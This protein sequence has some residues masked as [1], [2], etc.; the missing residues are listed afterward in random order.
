MRKL[1]FLAHRV[2]YPPNKGDKIRS[3]N[4]LRHLAQ[5][6][7]VRLGAFVDDPQDMAD[8]GPLHELCDEVFLEPLHGRI[9][10][11]QSAAGLFT[12]EPLS[13]RYFRSS[14]M[15][16]WVERALSDWQP[17]SVFVFSS[18]MAQYVMPRVCATPLLICDMV[19]VDSAKWT[20]YAADARFPMNLVFAREGRSL[21]AY[22]RRIVREFDATTLVS[23][24]ERAVYLAGDAAA[25]ERVHAFRN[26]VDLA[27]FDPALSHPSPFTDDAPVVVFT[28]AMDYRANIDAVGWY[29]EQ[30]HPLVRAAVP[31]A[32]FVI[33]GSNPTTEVVR[34]GKL[35]GIDVTGRVEDV[36]PYLAHACCVVAP[37]RVARGLQN[38]VLEAMA[39]DRPLVVT[40]AAIEG[41]PHTPSARLEVHDDAEAFAAAVVASL[42]A[43]DQ[44]LAGP[45]S[46]T[47]VERDFSWAANLAVLDD[48]LARR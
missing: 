35:P 45:P 32:R 40:H 17:D 30:V 9:K 28:G 19:D 33:V 4:I 44:D 16:R 23:D 43:R 18:T 7:E 27:Y 42:Q 6:F 15:R 24:E 11:L 13:V 12:G 25:T 38:K 10:R 48:I 26:G 5:S 8:V 21:A 47:V 39:L 31:A 2:P 36:R 22:E 34:L 1:L 41:I 20:Q 46:R 37:L 29:A 14:A 3:F